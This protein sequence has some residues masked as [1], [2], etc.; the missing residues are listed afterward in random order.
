TLW[1]YTIEFKNEAQAEKKRYIDLIEKLVKDIINDEVKTQLPQ[2]L[3]KVV[4]DFVTPV[5]KSII[6]KSLKDVVLAKSSSQPQST[7]KAAAS[8][9]EFKINLTADEPKELYKALDKDE[10]P[11][12]G[13][14]Q[15]M[16]RRKTCK[17]VESTKGLKS[18]ESKSTSSSKG[19]TRSQPKSYDKSTK[20]DEAIPIVDDTE[21]QQTGQ[22]HGQ[23]TDDQPNC[24]GS[25]FKV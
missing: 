24:Q 17:D 9:K 25:S 3:P 7:Y 19:T 11:P 8:L 16:I 20:A 18:K 21:V 4:S 5:I 12:A 14:D 6:T 22:R 10:D 13:S 23:N 15:R 2:I 1:T